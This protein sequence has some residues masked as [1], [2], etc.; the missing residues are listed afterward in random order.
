ADVDQTIA[1]ADA[2]QQGTGGPPPEPEADYTHRET[3]ASGARSGGLAGLCGSER[4]IDN[5]AHASA[6]RLLD[7]H[8]RQ[9][10]DVVP[11]AY[12]GRAAADVPPDHVEESRRGHDVVRARPVM[13]VAG[14][15]TRGTFSQAAG[16]P[17]PTAMGE[18]AAPRGSRPRSRARRARPEASTEGPLAQSAGRRQQAALHR[19]AAAG[20]R[21]AANRR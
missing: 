4:S 3:E 1:R 11:H 19:Q 7:D 5:K 16:T 18:P 13:E 15:R 20:Q 2:G 21:Q 12:P 9:P 14:R 17:A 8:L 6:L 10:A